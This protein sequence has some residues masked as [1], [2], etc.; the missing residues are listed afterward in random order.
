MSATKIIARTQAHRDVEE[1]VEFYRRE[2]GNSVAL[3]FVDALEAAFR[4]IA[5]HP[6]SGFNRYAHELNLPG[7]KCWPVKRHPYLVFCREAEAH[8]DVWRVLHAERDIP[9]WMRDPGII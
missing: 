3:G 2:A 9:G 1:A 4:H 7:L 5:S 8:I 6:R